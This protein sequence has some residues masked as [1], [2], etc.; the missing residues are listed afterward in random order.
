MAELENAW[1]N[2]TNNNSTG[3]VCAPG[4]ILPILDETEWNPIIRGILYFVFLM[5]AFIGVSVVTDI[6][7]GAV[8]N[9]T[10][11]TRKVYLAKSRSKKVSCSSSSRALYRVFQLWD[12]SKQKSPAGY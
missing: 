10:S 7:M 11:K 8:V 3:G 2:A 12:I 6:F 5:Y 1:G 4:L 9:I